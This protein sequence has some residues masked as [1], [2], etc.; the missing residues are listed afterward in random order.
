M[1][2]SVSPN[3]A[4]DRSLGFQRVEPAEIDRTIRLPLLFFFSSALFWLV[5]ASLL[6]LLATIQS[7]A[8][9]DWWSIPGVP[10]LT[11]GRVYPAF[12]NAFVYGWASLAGVGIGIWILTRFGSAPI[13]GGSLA[14]CAGI[15]WN[16]GVVTGLIG[17]LGGGGTGR[18]LLEISPGAAFSILLALVI[19]AVWAIMIFWSRRTAATFVS[20]WYLLGAFLW[21]PWSYLTA[22]VLLNVLGIPGPA[23]PVLHWWYVNSVIGLWL[24]PIGLAAGYYFIARIV[25]RPIYSYHLA[26]LGFWGLAVFAGWTGMAN[27]VGG[28]LPA[29]MITASIVAN[30]LVIIPVI[31]VAANFHLT[32][33]R[34]FEVLSWN[35]AL[36]FIVVGAMIYTFAG[37]WGGLN[38]LRDISR[39][40][41]FTVANSART[42][43]NLYGFFSMVAFGA[44]YYIVPRLLQK[45]W[46][47]LGLV[48]THF[49]LSV[50]GLGFLCFELTVGGII[51]GFGLLDP[52]IPFSAV[53]DLMKPFL[54]MQI[55]AV[56]LLTVANLAA[57]GSFVTIFLNSE[58]GSRKPILEEATLEASREVPVA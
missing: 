5:V 52:K 48:K 40:T 35:L 31:A 42:P 57:T 7:Y 23:Q 28:P 15:L 55:L 22:N 11:F 8:P 56:G 19:I 44:L 34:D 25:N 45:D 43:L 36:R 30:M 38:S 10:W 14:L 27:L 53:G 12:L 50:V 29:W 20:Q 32:I 47:S 3:P 18:E 33:R 2:E 4:S 13:R 21:F 41:G 58:R 51:Q 26:L 54:F 37:I 16:I 17:I 24:T 1:S 49:W 39:I 6:W 9:L 46:L